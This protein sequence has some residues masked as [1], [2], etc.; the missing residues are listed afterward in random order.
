MTVKE[1]LSQGYRLEQRIKMHQEEIEGLRSLAISVGSLGFNENHNATK[2]TDAPFEKVLLKI[3][4]AESKE[5]E[6]LER[7][8]AFK[9]EIRTVINKVSNMDERIV[10]YHRY[11]NN[12]TWVEIGQIL[13]WDERTIRRLHSRACAYIVIPKHPT[14]I[15]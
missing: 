6:M 15:V 7:L 12:K 1:Y 9:D 2:N 13:G 5:A 8:L 11:L 14:V 10:L 3:I 4:D